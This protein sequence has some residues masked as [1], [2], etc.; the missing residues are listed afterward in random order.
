MDALRQLAHQKILDIRLY[1]ERLGSY[2]LIIGV[3]NSSLV[4]HRSAS[5]NE[6]HWTRVGQ[7]PLTRFLLT[8]GCVRGPK[9][10]KFSPH[11]KAEAVQF[12]IETGRPFVEVAR[13]LGIHEGS[14]AAG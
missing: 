13:E 11:F 2:R 10:R 8:R 5:S 1:V 14:P 4:R 12:V 3:I 7:R 6:G 9:L